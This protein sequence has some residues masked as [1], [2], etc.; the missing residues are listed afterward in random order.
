MAK[1]PLG[2]ES[3]PGAGLRL[4]GLWQWWLPDSSVL[5]QLWASKHELS[6]WH[7]RAQLEGCSVLHH[8]LTAW[9]GCSG[10]VGLLRHRNTLATQSLFLGHAPCKG[11]G[12]GGETSQCS[13]KRENFQANVSRVVLVLLLPGASPV[14]LQGALYLD[15]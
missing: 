7:G 14:Q 11:A 8:L 1:A 5:L 2:G 9:R 4:C 15:V 10:Q 6:G 3:L 13:S 12:L